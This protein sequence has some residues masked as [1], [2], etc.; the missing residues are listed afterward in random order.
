[1]ALPD[2]LHKT[3]NLLR[4]Y[5]APHQ[6]GVPILQVTDLNARYNGAF[7]LEDVS[8]TL[9]SGER[10]A[11]VGPNGAGKSTLFRVIAGLHSGFEGVVKVFG[12]SPGG[13][14]CIAY[15][16]Q[17]NQVDW[18]FPVTVGDVVMMGRT[19]RMGLFRWP[20]RADYQFVQSS[21]EAVGIL[22]L[23]GKRISELSGGQQQRMFIARALAQEAELILMDEPL[24]GLDIQSM[25]DIFLIYQ[26]LKERGVTVMVS[27]HD[28]DLAAERFDQ[29]L[30]LNR[31]LVGYGSPGSVFT[32]EKL[33]Q[34]YGSHLRVLDTEDGQMVLNDTCCDEETEMEPPRG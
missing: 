9:H 20:R 5:H 10:V 26:A 18:N 17:R 19:A 27:M 1:M 16:P 8:F 23:I 28:L 11:V 32:T 33:R 34:A 6:R 30:L 12:E 29:A 15:L 4:G 2:E 7:A 21:L 25:E 13:H 24:N 31:R 22:P 14:T 3:R